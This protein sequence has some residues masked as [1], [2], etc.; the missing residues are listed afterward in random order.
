MQMPRSLDGFVEYANASLGLAIAV[1]ALRYPD[2]ALV[3]GLISELFRVLEQQNWPGE[4]VAAAAR[5]SEVS[6]KLARPNALVSLAARSEKS[7]RITLEFVQYVLTIPIP[8]IY[9]AL[10]NG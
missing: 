7:R 1:D 4:R 2:S 10:W 9:V 6:T 5:G 8:A 3:R